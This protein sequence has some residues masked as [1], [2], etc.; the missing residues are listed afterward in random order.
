[1]RVFL[2]LGFTIGCTHGEPPLE[3]GIT[4][5]GLSDDCTPALALSAEYPAVLPQHPLQ[6][7]ASGGTGDYRFTL[8]N[9]DSKAILN[10]ITGSYLS[11][12]EV[13][14]TDEIILKDLGCEGT[15]SL[16]LQTISPIIVLPESLSVQPSMSFTPEIFRKNRKI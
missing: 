11:S 2:L 5:T 16:P 15:A 8:T 1:M 4:E 13:G 9:P 6:L 12:D 14:I 7:Q 10:E 3:T